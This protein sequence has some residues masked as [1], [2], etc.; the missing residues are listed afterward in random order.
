MSLAFSPGNRLGVET[1]RTFDNERLHVSAGAYSIGSDPGLNGG[2]VTQTLL[3]PVVRVTGL[4]VYADHGNNG[5]TL[6]HL[7]VSVGYQFAKGSQFQFRS[8][9]ESFIAPYLVDTGQIDADQAS[10][11][12]L[13]AIYMKGPFT[14]TG[15]V[16]GTH[17]KAQT[18]TNEFWGG[19]S[20]YFGFGTDEFLGLSRKVNAEPLIVLAAPG[21]AREQ[22]E[23]AMDWVRYLNDPP[24]T[25]WGRRRAA[26][27]HPERTACGCSRSTTSR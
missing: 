4:P 16:A 1:F 13:E 11:Y 8:R 6:L 27:G 20:D 26:N 22:V 17:L 12:A 3:Y 19:Y 2:S 23:Y 14:L 24:T 7:G 15:E 10:L 18:Q 5:V 9:P 21:T 25:D